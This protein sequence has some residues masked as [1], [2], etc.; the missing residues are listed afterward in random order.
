MVSIVHHERHLKPGTVRKGKTI[1]EWVK[2]TRAP[3]GDSCSIYRMQCDNCL[4]IYNA[5][6]NA[7]TCTKCKPKIQQLSITSTQPQAITID[8]MPELLGK[9]RDERVENFWRERL[10]I[11]GKIEQF[12]KDISNIQNEVRNLEKQLVELN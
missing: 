10:A 5:P 3:N 8:V 12:M 4:K 7:S 11:I 2:Q 1:L 9:T 6:L